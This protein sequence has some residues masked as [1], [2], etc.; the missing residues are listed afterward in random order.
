[1]NKFYEICS[2]AVCNNSANFKPD[3]TGQNPHGSKSQCGI[4][5]NDWI[6]VIGTYQ[7]DFWLNKFINLNSGIAAERSNITVKNC[8]F[9]NIQKDS[10]YSKTFGGAAIFSKGDMSNAKAGSLTVQPVMNNNITMNNCLRGVY[11]I[12]SSLSIINVRM[13]SMNTG[14]NIT[15]CKDYLKSEMLN[16]EIKARKYGITM[17]INAGAA[18]IYAEGNRIYMQGGAGML[19]N[20]TNK[21]GRAN[22]TINN[23]FIYLYN[24]NFGIRTVNVYKPVI[25]HNYIEQNGTSL[26]GIVAQNSDS[27]IVKCN[28]IRTSDIT[29]T[30]SIGMYYSLSKQG[31]IACNSMDSTGRALYFGGLCA[32][33]QLKGNTMRNNML[34]LY[35]NN[36]GLIGVQNNNG[37]KFIN[38]RDTVGAYNA[39][40]STGGLLGSAFLIKNGTVM[41]SIYYP[42]LAQ[43]NNG[44]FQPFLNN[45][46]F[47]CGATCYDMLV[48]PNN[49]MLYRI[50]AGDSVLTEEFIPESQSMARQYLFE[51]LS[52]NP[53]LMKGDTLF[54]NFYN[55]MLEEAEGQLKEVE[56]RF[57][58]YGKMDS[59]FIPMLQ[60]VDSLIRNYE[61]LIREIDSICKANKGWN[62]DSLR[63]A[64]NSQIENLSVV[65]QNIIIQYKAVQTGEKLEAELKNNIISGEEQNETNS[66]L[67][68]EMFSQLE[69]NNYKNINELYA[70]LL[71]LAEQCPYYG[72]EAVYRA[73][74]VLELVNDSL[75]YNDDA[76]CLL[77]GIY[78]QGQT[79]INNDLNIVVK[80]NPAN[81]Y[82][83]IK[84]LCNDDVKFKTQIFNVYGQIIYEG[85][86]N[87]NKENK[88]ITKEFKQGVYTILIK[89]LQGNKTYKIAI[90]R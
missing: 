27:T 34:G 70:Q 84:V 3:Y 87:C 57:E 55:L 18:K 26:L 8:Y 11:S 66:K 80:P 67:M 86:L 45:N 47:Q 16:N 25:T 12:Y 28:Q 72:G 83:F 2:T 77:Y 71:S 76:N 37:N 32:G 54:E 60:N 36:V 24:S 48:E 68:N 39:N 43:Q 59:T 61:M 23:N 22:Y 19:L 42:V 52:N 30:G 14:I 62:C 73:R 58:N 44:W 41:G 53:D 29:N 64:Y 4:L 79:T 90:I 10:Y 88:I 49:E 51:V 81:E 63:E 78:R 75:V 9:N 33:T 31:I 65:K 21:N 40:L 85:N 6:G 20:E 17:N 74:A 69:E 35:I 7:H 13:D 15:Q 46:P 56:R 5:L 50:I 89:T 82:V 1:M 38:Y